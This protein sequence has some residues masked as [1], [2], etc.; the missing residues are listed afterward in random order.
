MENVPPK[1]IDFW[2]A[3]ASLLADE[4]NRKHEP[5]MMQPADLA[6]QLSTNHG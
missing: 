2:V 4:K 5:D 6:Q 3:H 1:V